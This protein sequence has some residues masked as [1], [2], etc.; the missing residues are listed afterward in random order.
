MGSFLYNLILRPLIFL[1]EVIFVLLHRLIGSPGPVLMFL[2]LVVS[3]LTLPLYRRAEQMQEEERERV[4]SMEPVVRQI[5]AVFSGNERRMMLDT[6][7]R[8]RSY[9]P[10][11][12]LRSA[13]SLLLQ[14]PFFM[15]A[16]S[17]LSSLETLQGASFLFLRDLGAPDA[18]LA[19]GDIRI[20][21]LPVLMTLL[22]VLSGMVYTKGFP[23]REKL[24]TYG[25]AL[26]FL[27][28]LY[29]SP[30]GLVLYWTCNQVFS[31][32][33]NLL[34]KHLH[35]TGTAAERAAADNADD[36][37]EE[38]VGKKKKPSVRLALFLAGGICL[39]LLT[40]TLIPSALIEDEP[41]AFLQSDFFY[42]PLRL[43]F[44]TSTVA[45]GLFL[46][47]GGVM[48]YMGNETLRR[49]LGTLYAV[50]FVTGPVNYMLFGRGL[51]IITS[52]L[53]F[54]NNPVR[55]VP[56]ILLN[57]LV[58]LVPAAVVILL[59]RAKPALLCYGSGVLAAAILVL[60]IM[61]FTTIAEVIGKSR[62]PEEFAAR[63]RLYT[64]DGELRG[65]LPFSSSGK[66]V[67]V[68]MLDRA[69][70]AYV[71][72]LVQEKPELAE[73]FSG[74]TY[75]PNT[76]SH[77]TYTIF[78]AP[79]LFGGYEYTVP[80]LN[81][82]KDARLADKHNE[83]LK[84]MPALFSEHGFDV[85]V[86]DPPYAGY[87]WIPDLTIYNDLPGVNAYITEGLLS[88]T[89]VDFQSAEHIRRL[90]RNL[91]FYSLFKASPLFLQPF[92]YDSGAYLGT[93]IELNYPRLFIDSFSVL[94][95]LIPLTEVRDTADGQLLL[96]QN[97]TTHEP[98]ELQK[99]EY[100]PSPHVNNA[101]FPQETEVTLPDGNTMYMHN[102]AH[103]T[104]YHVNMAALLQIGKWLDHLREE[105]VYDNTR[106]IITSD[107]GRHVGQ[108]PAL[109][110]D[111]DW[112]AAR[113]NPLLLVKDFG[114]SGPMRTS[115]EFMTIADVPTLA[116]EGV[117]AHP[118]NPYTGTVLDTKEKD[119]H[120]QRVT[121]SHR[122]DP[123]Y[124]G[125][126]A[127]DL[128]DGYWYRVSEDIRIRENWVREE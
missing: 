41:L 86:C 57:L 76:L 62:P 75:Y 14:I 73:L 64:E 72:F 93:A 52:D 34:A 105:G 53:V 101:A 123:A 125:E 104:H 126:Y 22:N 120:D 100:Y 67:V 58:L 68:I 42:H 20:N 4:L 121:T 56:Q 60:S 114:A 11:Q 78:G 25:L 97:A 24:Q 90:D 124:H 109:I 5:R 102:G 79:E 89:V 82:R 12:S 88:D 9:T 113:A 44:T 13:L 99:P 63:E 46:F 31:L 61:N 7:Y 23:L 119:A 110:V 33:K 17:Y 54:E 70:G 117:I 91:F 50:L 40:G 1:L 6:Y 84:V 122:W 2:S 92:I 66:N 35:G 36:V 77:G 87:T 19:L 128:S 71:P 116:T 18:L 8:Q 111:Q 27:V 83:A 16:Y 51:G 45:A 39:T 81:D 98:V 3:L 30:A 49:A 115:E 107:H 74:F 37:P 32:L 15:A 28:L 80:A 29:R 48:Y 43:V 103:I 106:I 118:V 26:L 55:S 47:W 108:F 85:T 21:L 59:S 69:I 96:L 112:D 10:L 65:I 127:F 38:A 95:N 94:T